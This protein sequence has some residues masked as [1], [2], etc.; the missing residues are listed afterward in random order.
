[1]PNVREK[2]YVKKVHLWL[3]L[4]Q[5][6]KSKEDA[7]RLK[8]KQ[9]EVIRRALGKEYPYITHLITIINLVR[10]QGNL[11]NQI[12]RN[13]NRGKSIDEET[14]KELRKLEAGNQKIVEAVEKL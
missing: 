5:W 12:A 1:M 10:N 9:I 4:E 3:T 11:M 8:L 13:C 6:N 14:L 2:I 7:E